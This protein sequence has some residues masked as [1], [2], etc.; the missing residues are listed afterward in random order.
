MSGQNGW[1][2]ERGTQ[3]HSTN[4]I[5]PSTT[6]V[7]VVG[8]RASDPLKWNKEVSCPSGAL[9]ARPTPN[10]SFLPIF[11]AGISVSWDGRR[12]R[13]VSTLCAPA[14][15]SRSLL[16]NHQML[17]FTS[18]IRGSFVPGTLCV[19]PLGR[20]RKVSLGGPE[21]GRKLGRRVRS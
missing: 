1:A 5:L 10:R 20:G 11:A 7:P 8:D 13:G 4:E 14:R 6:H 9:S 3:R 21:V 17:V 2:V 16:I 15:H 18:F 19:R 12:K